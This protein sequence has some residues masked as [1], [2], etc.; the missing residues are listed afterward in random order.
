M[1]ERSEIA[2]GDANA[3]RTHRGAGAEYQSSGLTLAAFAR[4]AGVKY[5]TFAG[6][7][8]RRWSANRKGAV[9]FAQLQLPAA[10]AAV[11]EMSVTLADGTVVR[12]ADVQS[13]RRWC[14]RSG[15]ETDADD[16]SDGAE[17]LPGDRPVDMRK[18][19]NG[20]WA[21][22]TQH[23]R[24]DPR[25]GAA[26][27][28]ATSTGS[29]QNIILG[30]NRGVGLGQAIGE[31][32]VHLAG[33]SDATKLSL[34]AEALTMLLAGIDLKRRVQKSVVRDKKLAGRT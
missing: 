14:G 25:Q 20:L 11:T 2:K 19:F 17:D 9:R 8:Y 6:W 28:F 30:R 34:A 10:S 21:L 33:G 27:I 5:P 12:G 13:R 1:T 32:P 29:D 24:E 7:V 26:F 3:A 22:T 31:R 16:V 15:A 4:R 18:H 23:L